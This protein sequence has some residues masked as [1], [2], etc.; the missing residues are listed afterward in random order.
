MGIFT[1]WAFIDEL[2]KEEALVLHLR[3]NFFPP[4]TDLD[5]VI[6]CAREALVAA[7]QEDYERLIC[8][9]PRVNPDFRIPATKVIDDLKLELFTK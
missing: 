3:C 2:G 8:L 7:E 5:N 1:T 9:Q 6:R 4:W